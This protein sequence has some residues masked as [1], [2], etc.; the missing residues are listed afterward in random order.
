[1]LKEN[2]HPFSCC[3]CLV[4]AGP[5]T[6]DTLQSVF[7]WSFLSNLRASLSVH[8]L[9]SLKQH[10]VCGWD[11]ADSCSQLKWR[12]PLETGAEPWQF[13]Y[14][15][16]ASGFLFYFGS[17][18][19]NIFAFA[20]CIVFLNISRIICFIHKCLILRVLASFGADLCQAEGTNQCGIESTLLPRPG[21]SSC[22]QCLE[23]LLQG[24]TT[25]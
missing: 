13:Q 10:F 3:V 1:M 21:Y 17:S 15:R 7:L 5:D 23:H 18:S 20:R 25:I 6:T 16:A 22:R 24:Y 11:M 14:P 9:S 12:L 2:T 4:L 19:P 8:V